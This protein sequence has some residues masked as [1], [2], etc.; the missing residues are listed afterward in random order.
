LIE[1]QGP[2]PSFPL[3]YELH[4]ATFLERPNRFLARVRVDGKTV[5]AHV[6][7]PGR[8]KE[9]LLPDAEVM[10]RYHPSP[11]RKT[12]WTLTLVRKNQVWVCVNTQIPNAFVNELLRRQLLPE[13]ARFHDIQ[14]EATNG[15]SRFDFRLEDQDETYWLEVKSVSL[16]HEQVGLFPDAPT[17]RGT[18]HV[19]HLMELQSNGENA[20][21][22]FMVQRSDARLFA[23]NWI[24]DPVFAAAIRDAAANGVEVVA[25]TTHVEPHAIQLRDRIEY[26]LDRKYPLPEM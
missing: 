2:Y 11:S 3:Q 23:P 8:L 12:D 9:L 6:P 24:T 19:K 17:E 7:D 20:G 25:Y 15:N 16:V 22:L 26:D 13:F 21:V 1:F 5:N 14:P 10:V 4:A 18:R